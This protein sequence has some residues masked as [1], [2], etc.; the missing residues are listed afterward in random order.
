[1]SED[2]GASR[3]DHRNAMQ[4]NARSGFQSRHG[5]AEQ[6]SASE[7]ERERE[8]GGGREGFNDPLAHYVIIMYL[9]VEVKLLSKD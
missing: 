2:I 9:E 7:R 3:V 8:G 6:S 4:C 5:G 1:V